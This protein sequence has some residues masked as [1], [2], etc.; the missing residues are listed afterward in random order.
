MV[1]R[2]VIQAQV[3]GVQSNNGPV[4]ASANAVIQ[5]ANVSGCDSLIFD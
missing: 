2:D 1:N 4:S 3:Y 5:T